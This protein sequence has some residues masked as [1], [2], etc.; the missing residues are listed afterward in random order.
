MQEMR[1]SWTKTKDA[2][3]YDLESYNTYLDPLEG[4]DGVQKKIH[5]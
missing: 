1:K 5:H 4:D 2:T 3:P